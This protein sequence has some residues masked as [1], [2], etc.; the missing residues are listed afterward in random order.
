MVTV[1]LKLKEKP[2][3]FDASDALAVA[4]SGLVGRRLTASRR[5][6]FAEVMDLAQASGVSS[7][8]STSV[9]PKQRVEVPFLNEPWYC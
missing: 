9:W 3:P 5:E 1:L 4:I 8:V 7:L 2:E 6:V